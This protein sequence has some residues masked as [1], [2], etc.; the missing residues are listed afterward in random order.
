MKR[1]KKYTHSRSGIKDGKRG[2]LCA[3]GKTYS[4]EC[5]DGSL[6]AQGVG[7]LVRPSF[8][9][10]TESADYILQEDNNKINL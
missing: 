10:Q 1:R 3:D 4:T 2:C 9:L 5:C 8:H 6:Q 7:S